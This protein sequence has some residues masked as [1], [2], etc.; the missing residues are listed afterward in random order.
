MPELQ[1]PGPWRC[2]Q[3]SGDRVRRKEASRSGRR[4]RSCHKLAAPPSPDYHIAS[5]PNEDRR[6]MRR[7]EVLKCVLAGAAALVAPRVLRAE[8]GFQAVLLSQFNWT[9]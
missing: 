6:I 4:G 1:R 9:S 3:G 8:G 5:I 7:R 2:S